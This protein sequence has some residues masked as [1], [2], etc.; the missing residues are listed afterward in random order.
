V[1]VARAGVTDIAVFR[2][3]SYQ[4]SD[5]ADLEDLSDLMETI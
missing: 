4:W 2:G 5:E 3:R 1:T